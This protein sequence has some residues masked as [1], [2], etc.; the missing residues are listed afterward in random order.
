LLQT[1]LER[2]RYTVFHGLIIPS[3]GGTRRIPHLVVS[4]MG[5]F[6]IDSC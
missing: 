5:V 1:G 4:R 2:S 6:V 3:G